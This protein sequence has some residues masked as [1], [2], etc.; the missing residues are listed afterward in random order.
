[1]LRL[2]GKEV[3]THWRAADDPELLPERWEVVLSPIPGETSEFTVIPPPAIWVNDFRTPLLW[4][5]SARS[6]LDQF[7]LPDLTPDGLRIWIT[8]KRQLT[9]F[10][11]GDGLQGLDANFVISLATPRTRVSFRPVGEVAAL[12]VP[13]AKFEFLQESCSLFRRHFLFAW[14]RV[15]GPFEIPRCE[16]SS[17]AFWAK[18]RLDIHERVQTVGERPDAALP[19]LLTAVTFRREFLD[20]DLQRFLGVGV[21]PPQYEIQT[22]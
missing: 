20:T 11:F 10:H 9:N 3:G 18:N 16:I 17:D 8:E 14:R 15:T 19:P 6:S 21:A 22:Q 4:I 7:S 5:E 13:H 2:N 12:A 1:V